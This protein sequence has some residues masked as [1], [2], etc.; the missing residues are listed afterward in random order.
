[1]IVL[2]IH[3]PWP[4]ITANN[5]ECHKRSN[6]WAALAVGCVHSCGGTANSIDCCILLYEQGEG[7]GPPGWLQIIVLPPFLISVSFYVLMSAYTPDHDFLCVVCYLQN[8]MKILLTRLT[9]F[10]QKILKQLLFSISEVEHIWIIK[11][12][13][14][15]INCSASSSCP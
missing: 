1:M 5:S 4:A 7:C 11:F 12:M 10:L 15:F 9:I 8:Y 2:F 6:R 13:F 3:W 14:R